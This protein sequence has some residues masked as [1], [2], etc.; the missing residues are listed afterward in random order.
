MEK[1][2]RM[3]TIGDLI[4][5]ARGEPLQRL[6]LERGKV[7]RLRND[8]WGIFENSSTTHHPAL[9]CHSAIRE[10]APGSSKVD[11]SEKERRR[12]GGYTLKHPN[13][14]NGKRSTFFLKLKVAVEESEI[15]E[16]WWVI[17]DEDLAAINNILGQEREA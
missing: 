6:K 8:L 13:A 15:G 2:S 11:R 1:Q 12:L 5:E 10:F 9:V 3:W 14:P 16:F 17:H 7:Y 4:S